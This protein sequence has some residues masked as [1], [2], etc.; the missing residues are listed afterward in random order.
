MIVKI[1]KIP[2]MCPMCQFSSYI[3]N[4]QCTLYDTRIHLTTKKLKPKWCKAKRVI[5]KE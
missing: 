4:R 3:T 5:Y 1:I 2:S